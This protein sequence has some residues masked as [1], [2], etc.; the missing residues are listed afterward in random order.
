[1]FAWVR[2]GLPSG[3]LA[4][5]NAEPWLGLGIL[6]KLS[7]WG[8]ISNRWPLFLNLEGPGSVG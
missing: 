3:L 2:L 6:R 5:W 7:G 1:M 4:F 8:F